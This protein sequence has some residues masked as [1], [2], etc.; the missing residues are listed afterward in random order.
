MTLETSVP[1]VI[2]SGHASFI[3]RA[4]DP[5]NS[6]TYDIVPVSALV[7]ASSS[8]GSAERLHLHCLCFP[9]LL[10][11]ALSRHYIQCGKKKVLTC[12]KLSLPAGGPTQDADSPSFVSG[13]VYNVNLSCPRLRQNRLCP[14]SARVPSQSFRQLLG[15]TCFAAAATEHS[16]ARASAP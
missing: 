3:Y 1:C 2:A 6:E 16:S 4:L 8:S 13:D 12:R 14:C 7:Y 10:P 11:A 9:S 15:M 5:C